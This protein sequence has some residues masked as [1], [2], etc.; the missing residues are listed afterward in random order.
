VRIKRVLIVE[1]DPIEAKALAEAF[2]GYIGVP[3]SDPDPVVCVENLMDALQTLERDSF[4]VIVLDLRLAGQD[5]QG[6]RVLRFLRAM[7]SL[8]LAEPNTPVVVVTALH[9]VSIC[10]RTMQAGAADYVL[11]GV[12]QNPR[13]DEST[14]DRTLLACQTAVDRVLNIDKEEVNDWL[15]R[16]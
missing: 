10:V 2:R 13:L 11:K 3:L 1:D 14:I 4:S 15:K 8:G 9:D 12:P 16:Q 7:R 5:S 6:I